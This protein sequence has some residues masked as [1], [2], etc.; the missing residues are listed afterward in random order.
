MAKDKPRKRVNMRDLG[1]KDAPKE[2]PVRNEDM[3]NTEF[4]NDE[5]NQKFI[6]YNE[7][8]TELDEMYTSLK[9]RHDILVRVFVRPMQKTEHGTMIPNKTAIQVSTNVGLGKLMAMDNPLPYEPK[10]VIV[11]VPDGITNLKVGQIV[12][13]REDPVKG[14][15]IGKGENAVVQIPKGFIH[16]DERS[17]YQEAIT[18][19]PEDPTDRNYGYLAINEYDIQVELS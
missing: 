4:Y 11:S 14:I 9:M 18:G 7:K 12:G 1:P 15:P 10:A 16:P 8:V 13:L 17:K 2:M 5:L 3:I 6:D 19:T